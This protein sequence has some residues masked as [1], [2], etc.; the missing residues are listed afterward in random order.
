MK[1][2]LYR[3]I[4][5]E[6]PPPFL[7]GMVTFTFVLL[8]GRFLRLAEMVVEKGVPF[9]D[10]LRMVSYLLPSFWLFT[11]PMAL[12]LSILLAFGRLSGDSEVTAM[13]SCGISLYG[14]LPPPLLFSAL[15]TLGCLWVTIYAVPWGNSSFKKLMMDIAQSS[16]GVS[17]KEKVFNNAFPDMVIYAD[18]LDAKAQNMTGVIV[19]DERDPKTPT[20]I[21]AATGSLFS[22]PRSHSMEFQLKNGSIH[23]SEEG[24]G[25]RM[26]QFQEYIL[27]V[28]LTDPAP[29]GPKK[30]SEMTI[31][32]LR[33]PPAGAPKKDVLARRLE[34][35][36]RL[37]LP[38]SCIVFTFV[39]VP[40]GIQNRRSGKASG[41]S[42]SIAVILCYYIALSGFDTLGEK[43]ILPPLL[44]GWGPN[45]LFL[46]GGGYL[47]M[48]TSAEEPLPL[49]ALY[50]RAKEAVQARVPKGA[51]G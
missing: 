17:I 5:N 32:E 49:T 13:K 43:S 16:A 39:G 18:G 6:I 12:L 30:A 10:V 14:L 4:F 24:A 35:H 33:H 7:V 38:F 29:K 9:T 11:I 41:F 31:E 50:Q 45:L 37:A 40:L 19:H 20:T 34:L 8:M 2:T 3:Y 46:L 15:A 44:S 25:Y 48:K 51:K 23:R 36:S 22:D 42:L 26:V 27:R 47:F 21:F 1:K 28:A